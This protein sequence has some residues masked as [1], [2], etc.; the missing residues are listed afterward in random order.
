MIE[1]DVQD[2]GGR[3]KTSSRLI[4]LQRS[5]Q[6]HAKG[7][8]T[9][10]SFAKMRNHAVSAKIIFIFVSFGTFSNAKIIRKIIAQMRKKIIV[11]SAG[12]ACV[13]MTMPNMH[14][15]VH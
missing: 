14:C 11:I 2:G 15:N 7:V 5:V 3:Q 1:N 9:K 8:E 10:R 4:L 13:L 6:L 12:D